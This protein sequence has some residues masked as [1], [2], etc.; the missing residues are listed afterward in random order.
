MST[1]HLQSM[2]GVS[3]GSGNSGSYHG[4]KGALSQR[5]KSRSEGNLNAM[6][7]RSN[8]VT[9]AK[10]FIEY[11][12]NKNHPVGK[13]KAAVFESALGYNQDNASSLIMQIDDAVKKGKLD[14]ISIEQSQYGVKYIYSIPVT[15]PNNKTKNVKAVYQLDNGSHTPRLITNYVDKGDNDV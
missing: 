10:K 4:T 5:T 14:P 11:S 13:H 6:P 1:G 12:L 3:M 8:A 7:Y 15:G 2:G 9:D